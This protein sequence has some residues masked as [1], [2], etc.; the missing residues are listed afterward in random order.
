M[1]TRVAKF[2]IFADDDTRVRAG[3]GLAFVVPVGRLLFSLMFL[4][5][6][7]GHFSS[8]GIQYAASQG[9]PAAQILVPLSG[10]IAIVGALMIV[11]GFKARIGAWLIVAFL[12]P[13]T[14]MMHAFWAVDDPM[15]RQMQQIHFL[16]NLSMLGAALLITYFGAGP[17]SVDEKRAG[18]V[19]GRTVTGV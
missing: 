3:H 1:A 7:T 19:G 2:G 15:M 12:V 5:T 10:V 13:V 18:R 17:Y 16:K 11:I 9:V 8:Q 14:L 6:L 4:N